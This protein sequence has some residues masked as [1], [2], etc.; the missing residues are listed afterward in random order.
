MKQ[1]SLQVVEHRTMPEGEWLQIVR[2]CGGN[3]MH[4]AATH[5]PEHPAQD[6]RFLLFKDGDHAVACALG[7]P[8]RRRIMRRVP[9]GA[10]S[11]V[12]PTAPAIRDPEGTLAVLDALARYAHQAGYARLLIQP[13]SS[14][15]LDQHEWFARY[16]RVALIEFVLDLKRPVDAI[17]AGMHKT[18]RKNMRRA[19]SRGVTVEEDTSLDGLLRLRAMQEVSAQRATEK[20]HGFFVREEADYFRRAREHV[21][22][23][24]LGRVLFARRGEEYLAGLA[25]LSAAGRV[26]TVRSGSTRA[27]YES[28]AMYLLHQELI[29]SLLEQGVE[30]LNLGGVP[31]GAAEPG[32]AQSGLYDFKKGFGGSILRRLSVD[33]PLDGVG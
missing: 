25:F 32:H 8:R 31:P 9:L 27:G 13:R 6:L 10:N 15:H 16:G 2:T 29:S 5:R 21:Y 14:A 19:Q 17:L 7:I 33:L 20:K 30:E 23:G 26:V 22:T 24:K 3:P 12:L 1:A 28:Y 4:V 18:H 11:L